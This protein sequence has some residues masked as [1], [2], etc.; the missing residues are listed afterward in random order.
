MLKT[1]RARPD[2]ASAIRDTWRRKSRSGRLL[3]WT[4]EQTPSRR[5]PNAA[6][7]NSNPSPAYNGQ[8]PGCACSSSGFN[9][10]RIIFSYQPPLE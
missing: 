9:F 10:R 5:N 2:V 7:S 1:H 4:P 6:A 8:R 3:R